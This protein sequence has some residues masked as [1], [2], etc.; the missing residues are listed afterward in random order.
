MKVIIL[1]GGEGTRLR[2]LTFAIPKPLIP[3]GEKPILEIIITRLKRFGFKEF[4]LSVGYKA[5][6]IKT[7]FQQGERF[8]VNINY[9]HEDRPLG[10]A[11]SLKMISRQFRFKKE[12]S[13]LLMNG[14]ILTRLDFRRMWSTHQRNNSDLTVGIKKFIQKIPFGV[15]DIKEGLIQGITEKPV[16]SYCVSAGIYMV[17]VSSLKYIPENK[18]FT[19]PMLINAALKKKKKV[20]AYPIREDWIAV[21]HIDHIEEI[22]DN[23]ERWIK[24]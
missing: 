18:A 16:E 8:G 12:E 1:A 2:P 3:I 6:L 19:M 14:D 9:V 5:E 10:T 4:V 11:G 20:F 15:M 23:L 13:F 21:E 24:E 17:K 7:Y 22:N